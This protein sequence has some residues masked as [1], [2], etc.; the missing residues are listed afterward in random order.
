[1]LELGLAGEAPRAL[2]VGPGV[3]SW[4][5]LGV[6]LGP[7]WA[8]VDDVVRVQLGVSALAT[9]LSAEGQGFMTN[10]QV[11]AM[12]LGVGSAL[13]VSLPAWAVYPFVSAAA[14]YWPGAQRLR[15]LG[16]VDAVNVPPFEA[17]FAIGLA[18]SSR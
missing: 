15:A 18:W 6:Q 12:E 3:G 7:A 4:Y 5:R 17:R 11:S 10:R 1:M 16:V 14:C 2:L 9:L 8:P 13:T